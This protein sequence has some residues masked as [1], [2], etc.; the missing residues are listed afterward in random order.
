MKNILLPTDFSSNANKA[1]AY[2][3]ALFEGQE[4]TFYLVN[5]MDGT[6]PYGSTGIG[7]KRMAESINKSLK[8]QSQQGMEET[9]AALKAQGIGTAHTFV[10]L[11]VS[12]TFLEAMEKTITAK[13]IDYVIMGTKGA[14][15]IRE[16]ALGSNTSSLLGKTKTAVLAVPEHII[17]EGVNELVFATDYE[18]EYSEKGLQPLLDLRAQHGAALSVL[19]VDK[20]QK[21]MNDTQK[22]GKKRL[23]TLLKDEKSDF[24]ELDG[25]GVALGSRLF[26]KSRRADVI[27][28]VAK[29]HNKLLD[30]FRK[31][32]TKGMVNHADI[33]ILVLNHSN[34]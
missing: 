10:P 6:I 24:F 32:E 27:C 5:I 7:T 25:V 21:G 28:L 23:Q 3:I 13:H 34:F 22:M 31:S 9:M 20:E 11:S 1:I 16:V 29:Q 17:F 4:T 33:P 12:G 26:A 18:V 14:S 30:L 8:E 19:F 15:G 2:A